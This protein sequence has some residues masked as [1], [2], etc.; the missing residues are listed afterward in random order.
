[1]KTLWELQSPS[2]SSGRSSQEKCYSGTLWIL[3]STHPS[4]SIFGSK[5]TLETCSFVL[6][7][8][9]LRMAGT[10]C[11]CDQPSSL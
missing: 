7:L 10:Q 8:F 2:S 6:Y 9:R 11:T 3:T 1:L 5:G 4:T